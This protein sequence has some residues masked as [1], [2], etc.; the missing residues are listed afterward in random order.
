MSHV[1]PPLSAFYALQAVEPIV[2]TKMT[3]GDLQMEWQ[4]MK[5]ELKVGARASKR[6]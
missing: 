6:S 5:V 3:Q 4:H 1:K 2:I